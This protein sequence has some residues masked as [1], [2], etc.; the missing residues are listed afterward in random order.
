MEK[1]YLFKQNCLC[2]CYRCLMN[3]YVKESLDFDH[4]V[5]E[6]SEKSLQRREKKAA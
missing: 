1:A 6:G 5:R 4:A 2:E 3:F